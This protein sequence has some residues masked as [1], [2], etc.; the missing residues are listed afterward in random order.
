MTSGPMSLYR[1]TL[2]LAPLLPLGV[3]VPPG[4]I[5]H[6]ALGFTDVSPVFIL[7]LRAGAT[8]IDRTRVRRP[9]ARSHY[10]LIL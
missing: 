4:L 1:A 10:M 2:G 6:A 8:L 7:P 9:L 3:T 5:I